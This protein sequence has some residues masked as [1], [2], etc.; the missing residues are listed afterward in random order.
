M[1]RHMKKRTYVVSGLCL[2]PSTVT[3]HVEA[4]SPEEAIS[5]ALSKDWK[6]LGFFDEYADESAFDWQPFAEEKK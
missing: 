1:T 4:S 2:V 3:M 5:V 6:R